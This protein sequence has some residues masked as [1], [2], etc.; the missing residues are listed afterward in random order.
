MRLDNTRIVSQNIPH[1]KKELI[2]KK[3]NLHVCLICEQK[4]VKQF[5]YKNYNYF[6]CPQCG[7]F[8]TYPYPSQDVMKKYYQKKFKKGNYQLA[9]KYAEE[10]KVVYGQFVELLVKALKNDNKS[11]NGKKVLDIGCFTG[12]FLVLMKEA[13]ADVHGLE[14]QDDAVDIA[15]KKL[16]GR[17]KAADV[18]TDA[19]PRVHFDIITLLGIIE[20]VTDPMKLIKR[21]TELLKKGGTLMIQTPNSSSVLSRLTKQLWP[22]F[23]PVEHIHLFSKDSLTKALLLYGYTNITFVTHV[24]KLPLGYV[25]NQFKNFGPEFFRF[26]RPFESIILMFSKISLPFYGG[27]MVMI[28]KKD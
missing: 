23:A 27:E 17:V 20:H 24:K 25:Y 9:R 15:N 13:G 26:L 22:P 12:D 4:Q 18:M 3:N 19:F 1:R 14:L 28:A 21:S 7:H 10:Y 16:P 6:A 5:K 8:T 11:I 2:V